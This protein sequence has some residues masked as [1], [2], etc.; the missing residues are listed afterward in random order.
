LKDSAGGIPDPSDPFEKVLLKGLFDVI[1]IVV[2][3]VQF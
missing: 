1:R 3:R 2:A